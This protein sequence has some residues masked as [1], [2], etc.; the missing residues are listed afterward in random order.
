[1]K[2]ENKVA[3]VTGGGRGIGRGIVLALAQEGADIVIVETDSVDSAFNQYNKKDIRGFE[4]AEEVVKEVKQLGRKAMAIKADVSKSAQVNAA[5]EKTVAE[6]GK[7]NILVN[8]AGVISI[9]PVDATEEEAWDLTFDVNAKGT[10]LM[11]KAAVPQVKKDGGS[12]I[13]VA[14]IAGKGGF[15]TLA[16]YVAS[17]HAV[18]GF[19]HS[20]AKELAL[21]EVNVNAICPGIVWTQM[22]VTLSQAWALPGET[23]EQ[24]WKRNYSTIITQAR[25]QTVEDMGALAVFFATN[26][27]VTGQSVNVDGGNSIY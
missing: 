23:M 25:P 19:T 24:S 5:V 13:N 3:L 2:L 6:M 17:K 1:M 11:C 22:W 12:I 7:L 16:A 10:F 21:T 18:V 20:L 14:S 26:P 9:A 4:C 8:A 27:N 15:A